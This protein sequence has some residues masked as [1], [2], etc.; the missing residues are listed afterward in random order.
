MLSYHSL[1]GQV[2]KASTSKSDRPG[3]DSCFRHGSFLRLSQ[4]S[5]IKIRHPVATLLGTWR[6]RVRAGPGGPGVSILCL[7]EIL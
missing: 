2:V 5:D 4:T 6:H 7:G 3:F 1:V